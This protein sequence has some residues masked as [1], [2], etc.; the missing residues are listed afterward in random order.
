MSVREKIIKQCHILSLSLSLSLSS[1]VPDKYCL[2][3]RGGG[4]WLVGWLVGRCQEKM[5]KE[6]K[7]NFDKGT[8][9]ATV[10]AQGKDGR[11]EGGQTDDSDD[12]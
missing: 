11:R 8:K 6:G 3:S 10:D 7:D 5:R 4:I 2:D 12:T 1:L 9:L